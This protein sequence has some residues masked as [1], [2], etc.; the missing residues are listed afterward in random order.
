MTDPNGVVTTFSYDLRNRLKTRQTGSEL[1]SFT[2]DLAG[3]L[4]RIDFADGSSLSYDY[5]PAHRLTDIRDNRNGRVHYELNNDGSLKREDR[6]DP[7]GTLA[8]GLVAA[9]TQRNLPN[10]PAQ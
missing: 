9:A 6:Y 2:Y 7:D 8:T 10:T 3:Q 1:T 4:K 5:D